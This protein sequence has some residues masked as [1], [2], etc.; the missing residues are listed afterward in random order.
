MSVGYSFGRLFIR[1]VSGLVDNLIDD[2]DDDILLDFFVSNVVIHKINY[3]KH[4]FA[5]DC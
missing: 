4:G 1:L 3:V 2:D 5:I